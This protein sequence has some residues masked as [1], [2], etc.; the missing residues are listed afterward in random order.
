MILTKN[1]SK[2]SGVEDVNEKKDKANELTS[3]SVDDFEKIQVL[4][5]GAFGKVIFN[6][7]IVCLRFNQKFVGCAG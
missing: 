5:E 3:V 7:I 1:S 4:G 2:S 6:S